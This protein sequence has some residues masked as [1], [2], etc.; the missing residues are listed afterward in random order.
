[1]DPGPPQ[2]ECNRIGQRANYAGHVDGVCEAEKVK[3]ATA[4]GEV[5]IRER[6]ERISG[7]GAAHKKPA[8]W[9]VRAT[10]QDVFAYTRQT[11]KITEDGDYCRWI[12]WRRSCAVC[13][14]EREI[15]RRRDMR[16]V[17]GVLE[18][19]KTK[20]RDFLSGTLSGT[21]EKSRAR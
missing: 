1:M 19:A 12:T 8:E 9:L 2:R 4:F 5:L 20:P 6:V 7:P 16:N 21:H 13:R 15:T 10:I 3:Q 18:Q 11:A 14:V 17:A